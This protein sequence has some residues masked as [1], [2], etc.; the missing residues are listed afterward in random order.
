VWSDF[1]VGALAVTSL[2]VDLNV[3]GGQMLSCLCLR[4]NDFGYPLVVFFFG[5]IVKF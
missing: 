4:L 2:G 1:I 5:L 3:V